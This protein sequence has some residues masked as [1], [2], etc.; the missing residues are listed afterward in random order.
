MMKKI[1]VVILG[2]MIA[3]AWANGD[4]AGLLNK[5]SMQ[6]KVEKW[7][8]TK[9]ADVFVGVNAAVSD[10][11]IEKLQGDVLNQLQQLSSAGEWHIVSY[12]RN[13]DKSG[14]E[15][16][17]INA[18]A[19]LPQSE[20]ASLRTKAKA[21]SKPGAT[22]TID[23]V[24]FTPSDDEIAAANVAL[25]AMVYQQAKTEMDAINKVYPDQKFYLYQID[26]NAPPIV[27]PMAAMA[28][29]SAVMAVAP[30]NVGNQLQLNANVT[31]AAMPDVLAK[32]APLIN[33]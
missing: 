27:M 32:K 1:L 11:G 14:L 16:I 23:D 28:Q 7:V 10:A 33:Q 21:I 15:S 8:T 12:T 9:T 24:Q 22:Y 19:R 26:F 18:E 5:V 20:L 13:Q 25:R 6:L 29:R 30:L 17:Q 3:P 31:F 2:L 4:I